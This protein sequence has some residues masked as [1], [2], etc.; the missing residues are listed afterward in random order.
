LRGD[1]V[2]VHGSVLVQSHGLRKSKSK[3]NSEHYS[4]F[5]AV[6]LCDVVR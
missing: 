3:S 4:S 2:C 5:G 1:M 6:P